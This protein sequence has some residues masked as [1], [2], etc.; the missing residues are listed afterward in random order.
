MKSFT[1]ILISTF[2]FTSLVSAQVKISFP[3][4]KVVPSERQ[5]Q[6]QEMEVIGFIHFGLNT[7]D[8]REWGTGKENP[9]IF[10]PDS[11]STRQWAEVAKEGGIKELILT[12]KHHDGFCLWPS[13]YTDFSVASSP[14]KN[15]NGDVV[16]ALSDACR[17]DSIKFGIYLSPW[18][19]HEPTYGTPAY[20]THYE[21]QMRELLSNY[22]KISEFWF[23]GAKSSKFA[24]KSIYNF[25]A[26]WTLI[27]TLQPECNIFS[28]VGPD[29][30]WIGNEQGIAGK[31][32]WSMFTPSREGIGKSHA[33]Y[34]NQGDPFGD[35]WVPGECDVSIRPGWFYH[36][37]QDTLVKTPQQLVDLYY[38][39]VGRNAV[40]LINMP[41][42]RKGLISKADI[43]SITTFHSIIKETFAHNLAKDAVVFGSSKYRKSPRFDGQNIVDGK[44]QNSFWA[45]AANDEKPMLV[46][47]L[48]KFETFD[49]IELQEPIKYGQRI[50]AFVVQALIN[51][52]WRDIAQGTTIGYKR[53]FRI[54]SVTTNELRIRFLSFNNIPALSNFGIFKA[55]IKESNSTAADGNVGN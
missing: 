37:S 53:L 6:H 22:G 11:L 28:D 8:N 50:G 46:I 48:K 52:K 49:R 24:K 31:T 3:P 29:A 33:L 42:N 41:P 32:N 2:L 7:F 17:E 40:L 10:D 1:I 26:W 21:N 51:S 16:K 30:R 18:D 12:A 47:Q 14:W 55:S 23:D 19:M 20:V 4:N 34:Q 25:K 27:R 15:G 9:E 54:H 43:K 38:K 5:I 36:P 13:K 35:K 45:A 44:P 39:S